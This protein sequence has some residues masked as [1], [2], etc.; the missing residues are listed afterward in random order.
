ME[1]S[2][3]VNHYRSAKQRFLKPLLVQ[4]FT[5][6][7]PHHFGPVVREK[8]ADDLIAMFE[9][10]C[11]DSIHLQHG[12][13]VWNALDKRT[14]GDDPNRRYVPVTLSLVT[15]QDIEELEQGQT[16]SRIAQ[17]VVARIIRQAYDQGGILSMRDI[18][19]ITS[20]HSSSVSA[21]RKQYEERHQCVLPHT[22]TKHD[23]GSCITHK[24]I[25]LRKIILEKKDPTT[26]AKECK[27][28]Q[29]AVDRY[30]KD[31]Y[32]VKTAYESNSDPDYIHQVTG[33]ARHVVKQYIHIMRREKEQQ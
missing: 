8:I 26:A 6:E 30:L 18:G 5:R 20:R 11:P 9:R 32:R 22:G 12:Q 14:R 10:S 3:G 13:M 27:H 28:S 31:Y 16:S 23:M 19:L 33:I 15:K 29:Q 1:P 2:Y 21:I 25:I 7:F 17:K 4:F 24:D